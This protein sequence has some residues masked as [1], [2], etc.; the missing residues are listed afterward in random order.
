MDQATGG[1][2]AGSAAVGTFDS[3][4][5]RFLGGTNNIELQ[6]QQLQA[7]HE[8]LQRDYGALLEQMRL[9]AASKVT[10]ISKAKT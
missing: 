4:V 10:P 2:G 1:P 9:G 3:G 8:K 6:L 5:A 7:E